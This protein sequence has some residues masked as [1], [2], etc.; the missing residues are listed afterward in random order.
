M[1]KQLCLLT[2][3]PDMTMEQ[4]KARYEDFHSKLAE[5]LMPGALRYQRRFVVSETNPVTGGRMAVPFDCLTE[6]WWDSREAFAAGMAELSA[7]EGHRLLY[8]DEEKI[9]PSHN[10]PVFSVEEEETPTGGW[11]DDEP[12]FKLLHLLKRRPGLS[13]EEF[14]R[15]YETAQTAAGAES[16]DARRCLRRYVQLEANPISGEVIEL[17]FDVILEVWWPSRPA[18]EESLQVADG[19]RLGDIFASPE[20]PVFT[21]EEYDSVM[22]GRSAASIA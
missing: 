7:G 1:F 6:I 11:R 4:F 12:Q 8:E 13:I 14:R 18:S 15:R 19:D 22:P 16:T 5:R 17:P 20:H 9:F 21:V 3:K 10:N 2:R